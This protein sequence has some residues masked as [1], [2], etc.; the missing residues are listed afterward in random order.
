M[1]LVRAVAQVESESVDS[2]NIELCKPLNG[3]ALSGILEWSHCWLIFFSSGELKMEACEIDS[4]EQRRL[5]LRK[6]RPFS[7][8]SAI[9]VDI[10][11]VHQLDLHISNS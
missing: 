9:L 4:A 1:V 5:A 3:E 10:K 2:L 11:P 7:L 8:Q 6:L